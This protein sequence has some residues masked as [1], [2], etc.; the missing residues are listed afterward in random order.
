MSYTHET[1]SAEVAHGDITRLVGK[2][3]IARLAPSTEAG[4]PSVI[5][6]VQGVLSSL[7]NHWYALDPLTGESWAIV[8]YDNI[9]SISPPTIGAPDPM[10]KLNI[11]A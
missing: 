4:K 6:G 7:G 9:E 1:F 8:H 2:R 11:R 3:V 5:M 10:Y